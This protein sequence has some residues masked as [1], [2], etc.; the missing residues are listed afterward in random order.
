LRALGI[1]PL[2]E[3][4][5]FDYDFGVNPNGH[6]YG[7][8]FL[9][10]GGLVEGIDKRPDRQQ[11]P[12]VYWFTTSFHAGTLQFGPNIVPW[13]FSLESLGCYQKRPKY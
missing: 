2:K 3:W 13:S 7:G 4:E 10:V 5:V 12:F 9:F 1:D 11:E 8:W 6:L